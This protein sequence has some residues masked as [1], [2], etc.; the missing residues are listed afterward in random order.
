MGED[1]VPL[2]PRKP[3]TVVP[4]ASPL[5]KLAYLACSFDKTP[6]S[7]DG[8]NTTFNSTFSPTIKETSKSTLQ[9]NKIDKLKIK[10]NFNKHDMD[11]CSE[12]SLLKSSPKKPV[13]KSEKRQL[14]LNLESYVN[15]FSEAE[16]VPLVKPKSI[17]RKKISKRART[18]RNTFGSQASRKKRKN[19]WNDS[20]II[21]LLQITKVMIDC[22]LKSVAK[23]LF[24]CIERSP[25]KS[26]GRA[27]EKKLK[28]MEIFENWKK[29]DRKKIIENIDKKLRAFGPHA[30]DIDNRV[31][32]IARK[33]RDQ[34]LGQRYFTKAKPTRASPKR[35]V[36]PKEKSIDPNIRASFEVYKLLDAMVKTICQAKT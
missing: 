8:E 20:E 21:T 5:T 23:A 14:R 34:E 13:S 30:I 25:G 29:C 4:I 26:Y 24:E 3:P 7:K 17:K 19:E 28:R 35:I 36:K 31:F 15:S 32:L 16:T 33:Y 2:T 12:L 18:G 27:A 22:E 9:V 11:I 1:K 10:L 6:L